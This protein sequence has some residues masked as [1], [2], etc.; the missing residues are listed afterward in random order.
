[1]DKKYFKSAI[2][3]LLCDSL[4]E[5][6]GEIGD[7]EKDEFLG[8]AYASADCLSTGQSRLGSVMIEAMACGTPVIAYAED[9]VRDNGRR[10]YRLHRRR[11]GRCGGGSAPD[12]QSSAGGAVGKSDDGASLPLAWPMTTCGCTG[13]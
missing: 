8:N 11:T 7:R 10:S 1:M 6:V 9:A 5:V 12:S 13:D 2:E 3:P 4:V